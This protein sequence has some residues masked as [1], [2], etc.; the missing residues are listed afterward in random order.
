M[1]KYLS[2]DSKSDANSVLFMRADAP[3]AALFEGAC[4]RQYAVLELLK[5]IGRCEISDADA[6]GISALAR[7]AALLV[8]DASSLYEAAYRSANS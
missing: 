3:A 6:T 4:E 8:D 7:A 5:A 1:A 2:I